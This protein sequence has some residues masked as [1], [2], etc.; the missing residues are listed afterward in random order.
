MN[1]SKL[2]SIASSVPALFLWIGLSKGSAR[3]QA[4]EGQPGSADVA[5]PEAPQAA[6]NLRLY[7]T[8]IR[9]QNDLL[10]LTTTLTA[11]FTSTSLT[12]PTTATAGCTIKV[13]ISSQFWAIGAGD[14]ARMN[15][16]IAGAGAAVDPASLVNVDSTTTGS[17][18]SVRTF[19]W[20]KRSIPKGSAETVT[21]Q[22][23]TSGG[24]ANAGFR[25]AAIDLYQN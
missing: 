25:T 4:E 10:P 19:Q 3:A 11:A 1:R 16:T 17:F 7:R 8:T 23:Q 13:A 15:V 21:I 20:M 6:S 18:A 2:C 5:T 24:T 9:T 14:V 22:F 12:C